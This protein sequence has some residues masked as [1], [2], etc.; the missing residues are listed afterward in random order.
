MALKNLPPPPPI[1]QAL[2]TRQWRD[3]FYS[4]FSGV[5]GNNNNLGTMALQN[6][7]NVNIT[8]GS[9]SNVTLSGVTISGSEEYQTATQGQTVFTLT[10]FTYSVGAK[11]IYVYVNGSKQ[12]NTLNYTETNPNTITF[13]SGLNAGDIVEFTK[14]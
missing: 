6:A 11:S 3:W 1:S 13:A 10:T 9:I 2:D 12:V 5:N 4:V 7:D 14:I 8:G